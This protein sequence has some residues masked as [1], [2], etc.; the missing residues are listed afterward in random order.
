MTLTEAAPPANSA[1]K[2][3]LPPPQVPLQAWSF[4]KGRVLSTTWLFCVQPG[5]P[6]CRRRQLEAI[7]REPRR[8]DRQPGTGPAAAPGRTC[9]HARPTR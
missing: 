7:M 9:R 2:P 6:R 1:A 5:P 3:P 8:K 4:L